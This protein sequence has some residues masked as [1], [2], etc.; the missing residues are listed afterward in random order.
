MLV[1]LDNSNKNEEQSSTS[2]ESWMDLLHSEAIINLLL[3]PNW[4]MA[5]IQIHLNS[6]KFN[7]NTSF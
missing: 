2:N 6:P 5:K 4:S 3:R 7:R 1:N